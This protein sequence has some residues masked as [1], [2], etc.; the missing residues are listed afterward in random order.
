M[1]RK[2]L[3]FAWGLVCAAGVFAMWLSDGSLAAEAPQIKMSIRAASKGELR[4]D[5]ARVVQR[6]KK[7]VV[8]VNGV[9]GKEYDEIASYPGEIGGGLIDLGP[10]RF[11]TSWVLAD[12]S[13]PDTVVLNER[14]HRVAHVA[15]RGENRLVILD[16][17]EGKHMDRWGA[18]AFSPDGRRV[19]YAGRSGKKWVVVVDG[20][21][22]KEYDTWSRFEGSF[23]G[24]KV[25]P[26]F[27]PDS[28]RVAY[29]AK[30]A[31]KSV[32]VVDGVGEGDTTQLGTTPSSLARIANAWVIGHGVGGLIRR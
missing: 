5:F 22:G 12:E 13:L 9:E 29:V 3:L 1:R 17:V 16:G 10:R 19:A 14:A 27:S 24:G 26:V 15:R 21:E 8:V 11:G 23:L 4:P 30:Y 6:G 20:L 32:V 25:A 2:G 18:L 7:F 28:K 31:G